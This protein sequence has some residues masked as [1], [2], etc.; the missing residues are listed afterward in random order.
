MLGS[1]GGF[2]TCN[3]SVTAN[4]YVHIIVASGDRASSDKC[5][6]NLGGRLG[7]SHICNCILTNDFNM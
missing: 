4:D 3:I 1:G 5:I 6:A 2:S 7:L